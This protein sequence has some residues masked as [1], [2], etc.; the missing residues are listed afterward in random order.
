LGI[1]RG[2]PA[3]FYTATVGEELPYSINKIPGFYHSVTDPNSRE[4]DGQYKK[5]TPFQYTY[6]RGNKITE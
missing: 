2:R 3:I 1:G 6:R 5:I 4:G